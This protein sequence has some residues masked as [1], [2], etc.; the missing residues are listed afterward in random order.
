MIKNEVSSFLT[1]D[2]IGKPYISSLKTCSSFIRIQHI[3]HLVK[4]WNETGYKIS[5]IDSIIE[6]GGGYGDMASILA[7]LNT[8]LTYTIVDHPYMSAL[9]Y[10]YIA[11]VLEST[12]RLNINIVQ[13][14]N[15][16]R[17]FRLLCG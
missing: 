3:Y 4:Y 12:N 16:I 5:D 8:N 1:E 13:H 9:Q 10:I 11:S 15:N 6:W 2:Y 14:G 17:F 7:R